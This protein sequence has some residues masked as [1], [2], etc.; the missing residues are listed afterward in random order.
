MS[1]FAS[2]YS[3]DLRNKSVKMAAVAEKAPIMIKGIG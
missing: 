3:R 1:F 2:I